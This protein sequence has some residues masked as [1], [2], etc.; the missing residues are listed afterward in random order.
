VIYIDTSA[1]YAVMD[2][3]DKFHKQAKATWTE[4]LSEELNEQLLTS[5]YVLVECF[6]LLQSRLGLPA[7]R[8][9]QEDIL[10]VVQIHW[11]SQEDHTSAIQTVLAAGRRRLSLVDCSSFLVMRRLGTHTAFAFD[12]HFSEQGFTVLPENG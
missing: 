1:F 8:T 4:I 10:P 11:V 5:N 6:A 7:A 3:D 12:S 2:H 9:F